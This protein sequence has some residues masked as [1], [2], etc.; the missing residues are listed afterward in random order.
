MCYQNFDTAE[1]IFEY[2][3]TDEKLMEIFIADMY[4][5]AEYKAKQEAK[6]ES[7]TGS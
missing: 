7:V 2:E 3:M 4:G 1:R 5:E 6:R